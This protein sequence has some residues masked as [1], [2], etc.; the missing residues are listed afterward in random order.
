MEWIFLIFSILTEVAGTTAMKLSRGFT[1]DRAIDGRG[2]FLYH[3]LRLIEPGAKKD[4]PELGVRHLV[5]HEHGAHRSRSVSPG[6][7]N[8]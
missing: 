8:R 2:R 7:R 5:R 6:S 1:T 3:Q 4:Q